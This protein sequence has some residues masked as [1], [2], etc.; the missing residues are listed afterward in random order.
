MEEI[1]YQKFQS[2]WVKIW[3]K[4]SNIIKNSG[5]ASINWARSKKLLNKSKQANKK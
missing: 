1:I 4:L 2:L 3:N 5:N